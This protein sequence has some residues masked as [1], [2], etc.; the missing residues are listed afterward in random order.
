[1]ILCHRSLNYQLIVI[2]LSTSVFILTEGL[3]SQIN[4]GVVIFCHG[5][6]DSAMGAKKSVED[7]TPASSK[8]LLREAG[9]V[10]EY[11][12]AKLRPYRLNNGYMMRVW[13][14]RY[15]GMDPRN[16][17]D[18]ASVEASAA[19]LNELIED[20]VKDKEIPPEKIAIGGF[21]MGGGVAL[22]TAA[23]CHYKLGAVFAMSSYLCDD[24]LVWSMM[25]KCKNKNDTDSNSLLT[26]PIFMAHGSNDDFVLPRWG[27]ATAARLESFGGDVKQFLEIPDVGHEMTRYEL[28]ELCKFL[29]KTLD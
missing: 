13:F 12:N 19:Q 22:Q 24:S 21:S 17:E 6:G 4:E 14:D 5:S 7:I 10:F 15:N 29:L 26:S 3:S 9:I 18:T 28:E 1:M 2:L 16:P 20:F 8:T 27:K 25:D 23:R 11:P